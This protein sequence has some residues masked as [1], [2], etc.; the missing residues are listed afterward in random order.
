MTATTTAAR[1]PAARTARRPRTTRTTRGD[2]GGRPRPAAAVSKP[3]R[4][5]S[6]RAG[7]RAGLMSSVG[8]VM[9]TRDRRDRVLDTLTRLTALPEQPPLVLVDNGSG[10]G[11][12]DAA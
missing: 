5:P 12:A 4:V 10:D 1:R 2:G 3:W 6:A 8:V 11:T 7:T 9:A